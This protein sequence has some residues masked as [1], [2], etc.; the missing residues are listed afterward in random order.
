[1]K[2][3]NSDVAFDYMFS[4]EAEPEIGHNFKGC[5]KFHEDPIDKVIEFEE[6]EGMVEPVGADY[7]KDA[8]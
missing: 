3:V 5:V 6:K 8:E 1:M 4:N 2:E 7:W